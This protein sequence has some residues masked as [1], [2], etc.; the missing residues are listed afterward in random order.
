MNMPEEDLLNAWLKAKEKLARVK[1]T[2]LTLR[3]QIIEQF[4][5]TKKEGSETR[6][7]GGAKTTVKTS[8][9][10][11][12]NEA[13]LTMI[14]DNLSDEEKSAVRF[15]PDIVAKNYRSLPDSSAL[16]FVVTAKPGQPQVEVK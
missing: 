6:I 12:V 1:E 9:N 4:N 13:E 14:W 7:F 2:E 10:Y 16:R 8:I 15:K 5:P 3:N 11:T